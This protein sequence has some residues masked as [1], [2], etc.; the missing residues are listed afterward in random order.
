V[1]GRHYSYD[2]G[3]GLFMSLVGGGIL[4]IDRLRAWT[5]R[6]RARGSGAR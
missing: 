6:I 3:F 4:A 5:N 2:P 1:L